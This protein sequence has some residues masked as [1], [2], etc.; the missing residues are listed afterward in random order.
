M[1]RQTRHTARSAAQDAV[2]A[3][4]SSNGLSVLAG[5]ATPPDGKRPVAVT[6]HAQL[7]GFGFELEAVVYVGELPGLM[8]KLREAGVEPQ[9]QPLPKPAT[10]DALPV[11]RIHGRPMKESK[12]G[13]WFCPA[14]LADG[15]Y[16][17]EK[18]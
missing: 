11:C 15:S 12:K 16:C 17:E 6:I 14:K 3:P 2:P 9:G 18:A 5:A 13:G 7:D 10:E 1:P 8:K 4:M